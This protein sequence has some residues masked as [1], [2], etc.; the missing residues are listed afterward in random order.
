M[1]KTLE[2]EEGGGPVVR[3]SYMRKELKK[4]ESKIYKGENNQQP[5]QGKFSCNS[6]HEFS[7]DSI[8][9]DVWL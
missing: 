1:G 2:G 4:R 6:L 3:I 8:Y 9:K 7:I 5:G